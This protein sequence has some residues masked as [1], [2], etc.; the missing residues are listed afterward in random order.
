MSEK[1]HMEMAELKRDIEKMGEMATSMLV[2]GVKAL[3]EQ[4]TELADEVVSRKN[5]LAEMDDMIEEKAL[6]MIALYQ[7]M[8]KDMRTIGTALK[9][10][11]YL[12]RVGRYGK[13]IA[14]V[15]EELAGEPHVGRLVEIPYMAEQAS[16][17][18]GDALRAFK[19]ENLEYINDFTERDDELDSLRYSIF[20][21]CL[22]YMMED[23]QKITRC[24]HYIMV[25]RY[26][27]RCGDHACKMAE[28]VTYMVTGKRV[29]IK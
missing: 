11:T 16:G 8:A 9:L 28:K 21:E 24:S 23:P 26:L 22:T 2:D 12:A 14:K 29:E 7:P 27:E 19:E 5:R 20:R 15:A 6:S 13:D 3:K 25:A 10:I 17:M 4:D 1:F 18:V